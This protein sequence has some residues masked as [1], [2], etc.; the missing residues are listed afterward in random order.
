MRKKKILVIGPELSHFVKSDIELLRNIYDVS[1]LFTPLNKIGI[2]LSC[3]K[4][5]SLVLKSDLIYIWF[6][7]AHALIPIILSK[8]LG[9]K[10]ILVIGGYEIAKVN[11]PEIGIVYGN[12]NYITRKI[13]TNI[14]I[15]LADVVVV[16]SEPCSTLLKEILPSVNP[17]II[18]P[19]IPCMCLSTPRKLENSVLMVATANKDNEV[20]KGISTYNA[21]AKWFDFPFYIIGD[22]ESDS[23]SKYQNLVFLGRLS[24]DN[25]LEVMNNIKVYCQ[26]S[27]LE[28]F[29][30]AVVEAM[31]QGC[32]PVVTN[33]G[34]LP[35]IIDRFG[36]VVKYGDIDDT[37]SAIQSAISTNSDI[38]EMVSYTKRFSND[39]R[40]TKLVSVIDDLFGVIQ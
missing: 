14:S 13:I 7:D 30:M 12:Q 37:R 20:L 40:I 11:D 22:Y 19:S 23:K 25:V 35:N 1:E 16:P 3:I 33:K 27:Y 15:K 31:S 5:I 10:S 6:A 21:V 17:V 38:S 28:S 18:Y 24:H 2:I 32:I 26:I 36:Y 34:S 29:G 8:L 9:K 4:S 39:V